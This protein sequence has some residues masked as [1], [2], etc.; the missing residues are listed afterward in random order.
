[1]LYYAFLKAPKVSNV[2]VIPESLAL[3]SKVLF[4]FGHK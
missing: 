2:G 1:M 4:V 3:L